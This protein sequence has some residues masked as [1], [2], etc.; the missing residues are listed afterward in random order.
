MSQLKQAL[1]WP[2]SRC[3]DAVNFFLKEVCPKPMSLLPALRLHLNCLLH[4]FAGDS[5]AR[6]QEVRFAFHPDES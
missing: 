6:Q 5:V 4:P 2:E 3:R 1:G